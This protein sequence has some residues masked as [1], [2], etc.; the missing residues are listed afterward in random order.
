MM[1]AVKE[2]QTAWQKAH[3][4]DF[5]QMPHWVIR[6]LCPHPIQLEVQFRDNTCLCAASL[7]A[8]LQRSVQVG[9][10]GEFSFPSIFI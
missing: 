3:T 9:H 6:F 5:P 10:S 4:R 2:E 7:V 1:F 8:Q